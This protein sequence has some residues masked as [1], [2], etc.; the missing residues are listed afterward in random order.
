MLTLIID[1]PDFHDLDYYYNKHPDHFGI[2]VKETDPLTLYIL[3]KDVNSTNCEPN[4]QQHYFKMLFQ[5]I[6]STCLYN[7]YYTNFI[8]KHYKI[9]HTTPSR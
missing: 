3:S 6:L 2:S 7:K 1:E 9:M 4:K 8:S 5:S